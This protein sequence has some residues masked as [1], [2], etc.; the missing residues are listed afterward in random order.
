MVKSV[1]P[2]KN[3]Q[4][5]LRITEIQNHS[6]YKLVLV[7]FIVI[8]SNSRCSTYSRFFVQSRSYDRER[9]TDARMSKIF[10]EKVVY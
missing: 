1:V 2:Q 8:V 7:L 3:L 9:E 6:L 4:R 10:P 5:I